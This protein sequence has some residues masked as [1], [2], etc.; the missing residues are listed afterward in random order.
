MAAALKISGLSFPKALIRDSGL[1]KIGPG[2]N[3]TF[4]PPI[5]ARCALDESIFIKIKVI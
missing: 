5:L 2:G 1:C 3:L 4:V